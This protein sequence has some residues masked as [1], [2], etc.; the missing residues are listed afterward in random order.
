MKSGKWNQHQVNCNQLES[1]P[2]SE[3]NLEILGIESKKR[4]WTLTKHIAGSVIVLDFTKNTAP[5]NKYPDLTHVY[6]RKIVGKDKFNAEFPIKYFVSRTAF[7]TS[8][9]ENEIHLKRSWQVIRSVLSLFKG[10]G[11]APHIENWESFVVPNKNNESADKKFVNKEL[12][13]M[14][15]FEQTI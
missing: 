11:L 4:K 12:N 9:H 5:K 3:L 13:R 6:L 15:H 8:R 10:I 2:M 7:Y 1:L 14:L